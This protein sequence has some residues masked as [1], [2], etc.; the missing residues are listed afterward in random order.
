MIELGEEVALAPGVGT[1]ALDGERELER[2][3]EAATVRLVPGP[4]TIDIDGQPSRN[5]PRP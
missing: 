1:I 4:L 2:R 3:G 5:S